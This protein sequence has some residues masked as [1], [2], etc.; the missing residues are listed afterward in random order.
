MNTETINLVKNIPNYNDDGSSHASNQRQVTGL[1]VKG[2]AAKPVL[3]VTSSDYRIGGGGSG[4]DK[5]LDTNSGMISKLTKN[6]NNWTKVDLVR[7]LPRSEENH[8]TNGIQIDDDKNIMYVAQG[9]HTNAGSPSNNFAFHTEYALSAAILTVDLDEIESMSNKTDPNSGQVY[10]Y[11]LPTVDDPT[12]PNKNG[13]DEN[14]PFGGNDGLNQAKLVPGGPVQIYSP[15]FRNIYDVVLTE[16]GKLYTWDNGANGGWGGHPHNEGGGN[17]TNKWVSGEPGSNGA[18]PNDAKVNNKDGLHYI[19][20]KGY[21]GGHPNPIRA[22]PDGAGLF[23]NNKAG[24]ENGVWRTSETN[25]TSTTLPDDWPPLPKSLANPIEGDFQ[26]SGVDDKSIYNVSA[27]TNGMTEYTAS[28]FNGSLKGNLLAAS[29]N[30]NI[31]KVDLNNSGSINSNNDVDVFASN[32]GSNPLDVTAQGDNDIFPGT[33]WAATYGSNNI[34]VF[35][36]ADYNGT[37]NPGTPGNCQVNNSNSI[38]DDN[39]GFT[40]ADEIDNNTDPCNGAIKPADFDGT[41]IGG[42]LVSDLNDPDDDDDGIPDNEDKFAWDAK[43]GQG[44]NLP[45]DYPFLNGDPGFGFFGLGFTGLMTNNKDDY[46]DLIK[47]ENNSNTEIIAGGAVGLFTINN[48]SNGDPVKAVN[49]QHNA[50]QFGIDVSSSTDPF[51]IESAILGPVFTSTPSGNQAVGIY[52]GNGD[53]NNYLKMTV[54]TSGGNPSIQVG[55]ENNGAYSSKTFPV[56]NIGE[57]SEIGL[58]FKV[59]PSNGMVQPQYLSLIH[60]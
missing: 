42:F 14:D 52:I 35:E 12:R 21:Y 60:I 28:N 20:G 13:Q 45:I 3:Y 57:V 23:T 1:L 30:E 44:N 51:V 27:S 4:A 56:S 40:N 9:G 49:T 17:A 47:D 24:G 22:N 53:Q 55:V 15:G 7:G 6:G 25:N 16:N 18:G 50:Y 11:N 43:N 37:E 10:K 59:D 32:F 8:A 29:F 39:D 2:T 5:N 26:N 38:D 36:P 19:S 46:L 33:V 34:T 54:Y 31:Y 48:V 58:F 41:K